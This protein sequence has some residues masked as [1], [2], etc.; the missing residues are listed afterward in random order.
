M[1]YAFLVLSFISVKSEKYICI[2]VTWHNLHVI[3]LYFQNWLKWSGLKSKDLGQCND[4]S[5]D[6]T[7]WRHLWRSRMNMLFSRWR[8]ERSRTSWMFFPWVQ[9]RSEFT[10]VCFEFIPVWRLPGNSFYVTVGDALAR[11][12]CILAFVFFCHSSTIYYYSLRMVYWPMYVKNIVLKL[13]S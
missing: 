4:M 13:A 6:C 3:V 2:I 10:L 7:H 9:K 12:Q 8:E 5:L 1:S 11:W